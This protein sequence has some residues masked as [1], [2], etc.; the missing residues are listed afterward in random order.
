MTIE[1]MKMI[2]AVAQTGSANKAAQR[3]FISQPALSK[4]IQAA[5]RELGQPLFTRSK[6]GMCLTDYGEVFCRT[7]KGITENYD[8]VRQLSV[9]NVSW[10]YPSLRVNTVP[11]RFAGLVFAEIARKYAM[12]ASQLR[13]VSSSASVCVGDVSRGSSDVGLLSIALPFKEQVLGELQKISLQYVPLWQFE[14]VITV[15]RRSPLGR[16][17]GGTIQLQDLTGLALFS[18]YEELPLFERMNEVVLELLG[19][20]TAQ[21]TLYYDSSS[22]LTDYIRPNEFRCN[23]DTES[24]YHTFGERNHLLDTSKTFRLAPVP[25]YFEVGYIRRVDAEQNPAVTEYIDWLKEIVEQS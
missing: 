24:I 15:S 18:I 11:I 12:T 5:E 23:L 16:R 21:Y 14:P 3:L 17:S 2:L 22:G 10:N 7:A 13:Y 20:D 19:L 4:A 1:Q 8:Y 6:T 25:F 9:E